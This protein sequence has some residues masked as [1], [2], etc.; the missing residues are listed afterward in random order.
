MNDRELPDFED[1]AFPPDEKLPG[2]D[3]IFETWLS[4]WLDPE[5][6]ERRGFD[7]PR[8]DIEEGL[9]TGVSAR[10]ISPLTDDGR[11]EI[12]EQILSIARAAA[13]D[14][15]RLLEVEP[16]AS[17]EWLD[18]FDRRFGRAEVAEIIADADPN[19]VSSN[20]VVLCFELGAVLGEV[21]QREAPELEWLHDWPYWESS[22]YDRRHGRRFNVFYWAIRKFSEEGV[23]EGLRSKVL[24][25][26]GLVLY[27]A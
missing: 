4:S 12:G 6:I 18:A 20:L 11:A 16:P 21:L 1:V 26:L 17:L 10:E 19:D 3:E 5:D 25:C 24:R 15:P 9:P 13:G 27:G 14:W 23:D 7:G 2:T 8:P 22:L